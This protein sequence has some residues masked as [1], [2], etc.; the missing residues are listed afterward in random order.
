MLSKQCVQI[1]VNGKHTVERHTVRTARMSPHSLLVWRGDACVRNTATHAM[2]DKLNGKWRKWLWQYL[3]ADCEGDGFGL[4]AGWATW[5][6]RAKSDPLS[7]AACAPGKRSDMSETYILHIKAD[8]LG[9][10][11]LCVNWYETDWQTIDGP[12]CDW[13]PLFKRSFHLCMS[14]CVCQFADTESN[15]RH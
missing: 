5:R 15:G 1:F 14:L 2:I 3:K 11:P 6:G 4:S 10:V 7:R 12:M 13:L 9:L 8:T